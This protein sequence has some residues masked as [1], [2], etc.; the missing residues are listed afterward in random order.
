ML[1]SNFQA[2]VIKEI[3]ERMPAA[4]INKGDSSQGYPDWI[5]CYKDKWAALEF[6]KSENSKRQPNQDFYI[7]IINDWTMAAFICPE[8][9]MEVLNE[10]YAFFGV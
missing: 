3:K 2:K 6:K 5:V 7:N 10:F 4:I 1:E 9:K 8:N